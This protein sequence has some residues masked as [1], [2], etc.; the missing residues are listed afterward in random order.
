MCPWP[1]T[2]TG[3]ASTLPC[4]CSAARA[5]A[6]ASAQRKYTV[7]ADGPPAAGAGIAPAVIRPSSRKKP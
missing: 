2:S 1:S 7:Q 3:A 6:A 4:A 5:V